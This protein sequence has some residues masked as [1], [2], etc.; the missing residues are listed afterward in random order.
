MTND[1]EAF[2]RY[3]LSFTSGALLAREA[4]VAAPIY[5]QER[6]WSRVRRLIREENLLQT[7]VSSSSARLARETVQRL[8][9]L[10]D[11]EL[12]LLV[13]ASPGERALLL[14]IAACRRYRLIGNF[15][16]EVVRERYLALTPTLSRSHFDA[17]VREKSLWHPELTELAP[18]T[19]TKLR[20]SLFRMLA[21][22]GL[23]DGDVIVRALPSH[24]LLA[25]LCSR[26]TGE[27][28]RFLPLTVDEET[29][30]D[31]AR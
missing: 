11:E 18:S 8:A 25:L 30:R 9:V 1:N 7:R 27:S 21:D 28:L 10:S 5:L 12:G 17:Y 19:T 3:A 15:A 4:A 24:R 20:Q 14:W 23:L 6:D 31:L 29:A 2:A 22:A 26:D 16:E 13:E